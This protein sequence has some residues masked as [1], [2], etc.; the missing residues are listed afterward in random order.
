MA[1]ARRIQDGPADCARHWLSSRRSAAWV[2]SATSVVFRQRSRTPRCSAWVDAT[3]GRYGAEGEVRASYDD[4]SWVKPGRIRPV[5]GVRYTKR[6]GEAEH[7]AG[8]AASPVSSGKKAE[9]VGKTR[10][11]ESTEEPTDEEFK[12]KR[13]AVKTLTLGAAPLIGGLREW[14]STLK[15]KA[16]RASN[17]SKRRTVKFLTVV[18]FA[19]SVDMVEC[20]NSKWEEFDAEFASQV[21]EVAKGT[22]RRILMD[23]EQRC[24]FKGYPLSGRGAL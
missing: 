20:C 24:L 7:F 23:Y 9:T 11:G 13:T 5:R 14:V 4:A 15:V 12:R 16:C 6:V 22:L 2:T 10:D 19:S 17:R 8:G 3:W 21:L 18:E 1:R